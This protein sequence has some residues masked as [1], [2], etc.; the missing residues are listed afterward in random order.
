MQWGS[1]EDDHECVCVCV[2]VCLVWCVCSRNPEPQLR[3]SFD[4]VFRVLRRPEGE[5]LHWSEE[6]MAAGRHLLRRSNTTHSF[7][8]LQN[9]YT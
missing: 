4:S 7:S 1:M 9:K 2:C 8:D 6:D 3:P 5:L